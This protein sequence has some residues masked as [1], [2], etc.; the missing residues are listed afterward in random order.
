MANILQPGYVR[1]DGTKYVTD[2]DVEI[3]GPAGPQGLMGP[4]GERGEDGVSG[5]SGKNAY[6]Q[7]TA[8]FI[9][10]NRNNTVIISVDDSGWMAVGQEV[11][12]ATAGYFAVN[13]IEGTSVTITNLGLFTTAP[14]TN[15]TAPQGI[16]PSGGPGRNSYS[17]VMNDFILPD[18]NNSVVVTVDFS[19]WMSVGQEIFIATAGYFAITNI[20][21]TSVTIENLG[22]YTTV[23]GTNITAPQGISPSGGPGRNSYSQLAANFTVPNAN[24]TVVITV[25]YSDW[26]SIGQDI[27]IATAG[28]F[29]VSAIAGVSVTIT[30]LGLY[31]ISPGTNITAPQNISPAGV[32]G[33]IQPPLTNLLFVDCNL[34]DDVNNTGSI[35]LPYKT[36]SKALS[37]IP[38]S[39]T[40]N[41]INSYQILIS[42]GIY[43]ENLTFNSVNTYVALVGFG[44]AWTL[45]HPSYLGGSPTTR[46]I[47]WT[48]SD[49]G[50][51]T[52]ST[53][54]KSGLAIGTLFDPG[55]EQNSNNQFATGAILTGKIII[56]DNG[57]TG[58]SGCT[59]DVYLQVSVLDQLSSG[60]AFVVTGA[61]PDI[62]TTNV[63]AQKSTFASAVYGPPSGAGTGIHLQMANKCHFTGLL[64]IGRYS[65]IE[66]SVISLGMTIT[67]DIQD[68][69]PNGLINCWFSGT[70]TGPASS[71][72]M[73]GNTY[74]WF[75][76]NGGSLAGGA[77]ITVQDLRLAP[78]KI[79]FPGVSGLQQTTNTG[80]TEIGT[81]LFDPSAIYLGNAYTRTIKAI[82]ELEV[83][84][85]GESA[86]LELYNI[87]DG[88]TVTTL[89]GTTTTAATYSTTLTVPTN[90][91]NSSKLYGWRL[92]RS[93]ATVSDPVT[94][95]M[96]YLE[97]TYS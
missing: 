75:T 77:T 52:S 44:G 91:P 80:A 96:A 30:N 41:A 53:P 48:F 26:M 21:N 8:D 82:A 16:S 73:D 94:C 35:N 49:T 62:G 92:H 36:I 76:Q 6:S 67:D 58:G 63:F 24:S 85:G 90:L 78:T 19:D 40:G 59:K 71:A 74:Y 33:P 64:T 70:F 22:L 46:N 10:P 61:T 5:V 2:P 27:F 55:T 42:P 54:A 39:P 79:I 28:Y 18:R 31:H 4:K 81:T 87:T 86:V 12:I 7:V 72:R 14:G 13:L 34:G 56:Y 51:F 25:D 47:T 11:F 68:M 93:G 17:Q 97:V 84:T 37:V 69:K 32:P 23:P 60:S 9:I 65:R 15:I 20:S 3:V 57:G 95:K 66:N 43:D 89:T 1:W 83:N 45:G 50:S 88:L 29:T 38:A